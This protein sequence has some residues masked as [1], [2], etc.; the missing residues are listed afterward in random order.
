[1][2]RADIILT[3]DVA[4]LDVLRE[5][6]GESNRPKLAQDLG[7]RDIPDPDRQ[8]PGNAQC[9]CRPRRAGKGS[10]CPPASPVSG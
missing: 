10:A 9:V 6:C 4:A 2:D 7:D 3:M 1:M 5:V 8:R